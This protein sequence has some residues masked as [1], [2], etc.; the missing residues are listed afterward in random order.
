M[1]DKTTGDH[2]LVDTGAEI[3]AVPAT[4]ADRSR[5]PIS[6]LQAVNETPILVYAERSLWLNLGLRRVFVA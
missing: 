2:L 5:K 6:F 3:S 4:L 1:I